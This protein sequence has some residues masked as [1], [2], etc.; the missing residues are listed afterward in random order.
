M[1]LSQVISVLRTSYERYRL[2]HA[3][4]ETLRRG[5]RGTVLH[6]VRGRRCARSTSQ[7]VQQLDG[8]RLNAPPVGK[9]HDK[10]YVCPATCSLFAPQPHNRPFQQS[11]N[12]NALVSLS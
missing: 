10:T 5:S 1:T 7:S 2:Q 4:G 8:P 6:Q 9:A 3:S 12:F 11:Y